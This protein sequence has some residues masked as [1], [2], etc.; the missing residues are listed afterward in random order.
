MTKTLHL[1]GLTLKGRNRIREHGARW[2]VV[3]EEP[4][5]ICLRG[6]PGILVESVATGD[7]RWIARHNDRDFAVHAIH[8]EESSR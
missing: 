2:R 1:R 4:A 8:I 3:R 7:A 6:Q 5:T